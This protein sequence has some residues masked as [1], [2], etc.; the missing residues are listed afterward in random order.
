MRSI[1]YSI[2][3]LIVAACGPSHVQVPDPIAPMQ[4]PP[5]NAMQT[6]PTA[7]NQGTGSGV[8]P[9]VDDG[10]RG[11]LVKAATKGAK[12]LRVCNERHRVL[13][14]HIESYLQRQSEE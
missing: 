14:E 11:A 10:T 1:S 5:E 6:C 3:P 12:Y 9:D 8:L 13:K 7:Q 4:P 2:I